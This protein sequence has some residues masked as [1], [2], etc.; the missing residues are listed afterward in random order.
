[1]VTWVIRALRTVQRKCVCV[2]CTICVVCYHLLSWLV[3]WLF[4]LFLNACFNLVCMEEKYSVVYMHVTLYR[5]DR[6]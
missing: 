6:Y 5:V 4:S 3:R 1:M 2:A